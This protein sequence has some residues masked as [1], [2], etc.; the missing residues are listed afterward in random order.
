M[1]LS[2]RFSV[3]VLI[4]IASDS[5]KAGIISGG[6]GLYLSEIGGT[7]DVGNL[8]AGATA[9]APN[10][11]GQN[12]GPPQPIGYGGAHTTTGVN[13]LAYGNTGAWL[14]GSANSFVGLDLGGNMLVSSIAYGRDNG[15]EA[16]VFTDRQLGTVT[17]QYTTVA[18]PTYTTPNTSWTT[19]GTMDYTGLLQDVTQSNRHRFNFDPVSATGLRLVM[20]NTG[21]GVDEF[22]IYSSSLALPTLAAGSSVIQ[23]ETTN[24]SG[25]HFL[26]TAATEPA[27]GDGLYHHIND[28][29]SF[30]WHPLFEGKNVTVEASW[31]V[32]FNHSQDVDYFYDPDGAG[33]LAEIALLQ[34]VTQ[35]LLADQLTPGSVEWSG[36]LTIAEGLD[37]TPEGIFRVTGTDVVGGTNPQALTSAAW[38]FTAVPE[39]T[40]I[41]LW[42]ILGCCGVAFRQWRK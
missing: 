3:F 41:L 34:D 9:F 5:A 12:A 27:P 14:A 35:T 10:I 38:R 37:I 11:E 39:P 40:S 30:T 25:L 2:L 20:S 19:I 23:D 7:F 15:G 22:E 42:T 1:S 21:R 4:L 24:S 26:G 13:D 36:F 16:T 6:G 18:S 28:S 33:P 29:G 31:G 32:N 8:S 17:L